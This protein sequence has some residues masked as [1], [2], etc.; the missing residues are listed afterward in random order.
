[1]SADRLGLNLGGA[2]GG[3]AA[4]AIWTTLL[5]VQLRR[6]LPV[7]EH[8][9]IPEILGDIRVAMSYALGTV[10]RDAI[11]EAYTEVQRT[12][13]IVALVTLL[14][15][16]LSMLSMKDVNLVKEDK[17]VGQGVVVM[18]RASIIGKL[19]TLGLFFPYEACSDARLA[20]DS[21]SEDEEGS[22]SSVLLDRDALA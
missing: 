8:V 7:G 16:L 14:P 4:G 2:V 15:A 22:E 10:E 3:A 13:N 17:G 12:L 6:N 9:H 11:N 19:G 18:G 5:P 21:E 1:M 20:E